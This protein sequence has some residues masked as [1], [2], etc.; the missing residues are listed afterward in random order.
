MSAVASI[1][2]LLV[3]ESGCGD[4]AV[5]WVVARGTCVVVVT[6]TAMGVVVGLVVLILVGSL[7][8]PIGAGGTAIAVV[9]AALA[10]TVGAADASFKRRYPCLDGCEGR[11]G[12]GQLLEDGGVFFATLATAILSWALACARMVSVSDV[13]VIKLAVTLLA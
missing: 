5:G 6:V 8:V 11:E 12:L 7:W 10:T 4:V 13:C 1:A 2:T 3:A 9:G